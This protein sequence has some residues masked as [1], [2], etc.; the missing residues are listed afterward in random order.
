MAG[1][2]S[3]RRPARQEKA[4]LPPR[5]G[6]LPLL[7][8]L[9]IL[10]ALYAGPLVLMLLYSFWRV[11]NFRMVPDWTLDNY[12]AF[13]SNPAY[14]R[15][16]ART[17]EMAAITTILALVTASTCR[18][19]TSAWNSAPSIIVVRTRGFSVAIAFS[20]CTTSGQLWQ[21]NET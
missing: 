17:V 1:R 13:L 4:D 18:A 7:P 6:L 16:F 20:A 2:G 8:A 15:V 19:S 12:A 3:G 21:D 9:A 11:K 10:L 14:L 5:W